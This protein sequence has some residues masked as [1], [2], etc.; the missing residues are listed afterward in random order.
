MD[1]YFEELQ[2]KWDFSK[3]NIVKSNDDLDHLYLK[4]KKKERENYFF[5]YGTITTLFVVLIVLSLFFIYVAPVKETQ[6]RIG[7]GF[8]ISVLLFR[9]FI[10]IISIYKAKQINNIYSTLKTMETAI[11]FH[12]FRKMIHI[13]ISPILIGLYTIGFYM[14]TSEFSLYIS[15]WNLIIIDT[16]YLIIGFIL[17]VVL[18]KGVIKELQKLTEILKLKKEIIE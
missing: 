6:S 1:V 7:A 16:S 3:K 4:I 12:Q 14:L 9:I 13:L 17:F 8:M 10:E 11:N 5:Y 18:R 15:F 2:K